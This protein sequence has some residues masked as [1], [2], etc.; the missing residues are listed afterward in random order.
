MTIHP[1]AVSATRSNQQTVLDPMNVEEVHAA[2][3]EASGGA[4]L[5]LINSPP[6]IFGPLPL[7]NES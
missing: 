6:A 7:P 1:A 5:T 2:W 4:Q 3:R